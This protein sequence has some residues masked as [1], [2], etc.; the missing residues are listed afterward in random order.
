MKVKKENIY[1]IIKTI[2][3]PY[4]NIGEQIEH[5]TGMEKL[6]KN[7][8]D[9]E[10]YDLCKMI[11]IVSYDDWAVCLYQEDKKLYYL[12]AEEIVEVTPCKMAISDDKYDTAIAE[13]GKVLNT[14]DDFYMYGGGC[15]CC[16]MTDD[17]RYY[18]GFNRA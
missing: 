7:T 8:K 10:K 14:L 9:K 12:D 17:M 18:I 5:D 1:E 16:G 2:K 15:F 3:S 11:P 6:F 4:R 13:D